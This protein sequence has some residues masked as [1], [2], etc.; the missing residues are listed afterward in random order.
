MKIII[1]PR[2]KNKRSLL[3]V[4]TVRQAFEYMI[5]AAEL[6]EKRICGPGE[7]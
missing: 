1:R 3:L 6:Q 5:N 2:K 7:A 4:I